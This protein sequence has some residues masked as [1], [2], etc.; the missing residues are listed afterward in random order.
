VEVTMLM[1]QQQPGPPPVMV[2]LMPKSGDPTGLADVLIGALG[3]TGAL[4]LGAVVLALVFAAALFVFRWKFGNPFPS[5]SE[6]RP[7]DDGHSGHITR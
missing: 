2:R 4:V 1:F 5:A 7:G 3:L 6:Q